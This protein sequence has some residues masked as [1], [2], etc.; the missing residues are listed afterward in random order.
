MER[1]ECTLKII[2]V[3]IIIPF[4]KYK[5]VCDFQNKNLYSAMQS[6]RFPFENSEMIGLFV[7]K[8]RRD[9]PETSME[10]LVRG[11]C[12]PINVKATTQA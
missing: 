10:L 9:S 4:H 5:S 8:T 12:F 7:M 11:Y 1:I 2:T 6:N 3:A